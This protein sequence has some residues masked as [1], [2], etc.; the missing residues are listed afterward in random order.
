VPRYPDWPGLDDF[1]GPAFHTA[2]WEHQHD[3][4][5]KI[6]AVVGT[7]SS[8]TQIVPAIQPIVRRLYLFQRE[9]GWVLPKGEHDFADE[10]QAELATPW[11]RT[12]ERWRLKFLLE[13]NLWGG[14]IWRPGTKANEARERLCLEYIARKFADRPDLQEAVTPRYPYPGKRPASAST[15]YSALEKPS[16]SSRASRR[17]GTA[18]SSRRWTARPGP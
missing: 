11:R 12:R 9:P 18:G 5:G 16:R 8:A 13:K 1:E 6:V 7:G 17:A 2:R 10:E 14:H 4:T 15:C 3:L